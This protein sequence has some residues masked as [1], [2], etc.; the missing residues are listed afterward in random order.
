MTAPEHHGY[1]LVHFVEDPAGFGERIYFSRSAPLDPT[2]WERLNRGRPVLQSD[3]GSTGVRD[4]FIVRTDHGFVI[5]ATDLRIYGGDQAGWETWRRRGSRSLVVWEST[6]LLTWSSPRLVEVAPPAA[7]MA[8]APEVIRDPDGSGE[9]LVY[10]SSTLYPDDDPHHQGESYSRILVART[11]DFRSFGP[12]EV[13]VDHGRTVIDMTAVHV[14]GRIHRVL[15]EDRYDSD[16]RRLY[17]EV[18]TSF[19]G[20]DFAVVAER[21]GEDR[22]AR[23]EAPILLPDLR[24]SAWYL[25]VDQFDTRPQGYIAYRTDALGSGHWQPLTGDDFVMPPDTKHGTVIPVTD[26]EWHALGRVDVDLDGA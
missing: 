23:V 5:L 2:R 17:E 7:G 20:D 4:P 13:L 22:H 18:G 21:I 15:K 3:L 6:D 25:L 26:E 11:R 8:W 12:V 14:D 10:W 16:S 19:F 1:L 24:G 9:H